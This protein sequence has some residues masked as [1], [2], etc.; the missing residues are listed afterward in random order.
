MLVVYL[1]IFS[2]SYLYS[3]A[4]FI[5]KSN[6]LVSVISVGHFLFIIPYV[7]GTFLDEITDLTDKYIYLIEQTSS[8]KFYLK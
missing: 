5:I 2:F 7:F 8:N 6:P 3:N 4:F 1:S